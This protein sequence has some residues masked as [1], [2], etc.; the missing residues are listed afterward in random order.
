VGDPVAE[1]ADNIAFLAAQPIQQRLVGV[2]HLKIPRQQHDF[3]GDQVEDL[4]RR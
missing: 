2:Q 1:I 4:V 3:I